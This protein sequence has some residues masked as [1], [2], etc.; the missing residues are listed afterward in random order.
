MSDC[1]SPRKVASRISTDLFKQLLQQQ[2]I[3]SM[4]NYC[5]SATEYRYLSSEGKVQID[6]TLYEIHS[7][8][9]DIATFEE[10]TTLRHELEIDMPPE[11]LERTVYDQT[12]WICLNRPDV[13]NRVCRF[14][15]ADR[16][17]PSHWF[18]VNINRDIFDPFPDSEIPNVDLLATKIGEFQRERDGRGQYATAEYILRNGN[19][20]YYFIYLSDYQRHKTECLKG[21]FKHN[22]INRDAVEIIFVFHR[23]TRTLEAKLLAGDRKD[24]L[25]VCNIWAV[26]VKNCSADSISRQRTLDQLSQVLSPNFKFA[27]DPSGKIRSAKLVQLRMSILNR[28]NSKRTFEEK[29]GDILQRMNLEINQTQLPRDQWVVEKIVIAFTLANEFKRSKSQQVTV[30]MDGNNIADKNPLV[31]NLL[32]NYLKE[33]NLA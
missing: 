9:S 21:V 4:V 28:R 27:I 3:D 10:L 18:V 6:S 5:D 19:D 31:Q 12:T 33:H 22:V 13:W 29:D 30:T 24:K 7:V 25:A 16:I 14:S 15:H 1:F 23:D 8:A 20:E 11:M 17:A 2:G 26:I 32:R